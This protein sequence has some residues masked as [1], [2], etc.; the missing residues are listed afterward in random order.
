MFFIFVDLITL[1]FLLLLA[2]IPMSSAI[3]PSAM[4]LPSVPFVFQDSLFRCIV[5]S[6]P[7]L[8]STYPIVGRLVRS[9]GV[10]PFQLHI[11]TSAA[12]IQLFGHLVLGG[13]VRP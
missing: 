4:L 11:S 9:G 2:L 6:S 12:H 7:I 8:C 13:D 5:L 3:L 1:P 10:R